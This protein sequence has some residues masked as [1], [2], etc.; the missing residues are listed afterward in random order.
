M[1]Q[2][3]IFS[4]VYVRYLLHPILEQEAQSTLNKPN[5]NQQSPGGLR[6]SASQGL[7]G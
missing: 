5:L 2:S 3:E 6:Q 7:S 1:A 4:P